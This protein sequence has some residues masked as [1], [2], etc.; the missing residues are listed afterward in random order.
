MA[1]GLASIDEGCTLCG[2]CVSACSANAIE[3]T[4]E[5]TKGLDVTNHSGIWVFAEQVDG[6]IRRV[7]FE[8]LGEARRLAA[9]GQTVSA[10]LFGCDLNS[11]SQQLISY[12]ADRVFSADS[13]ALAAYNDELYAD[14]LAQ[15]AASRRPEIVLIGATG[16][17]RSLAPRVAS[18]LDTGL[19]ADCT[20]LAIEPDSS[21]LLQT[22]PAF[23][24][25]LMATIICPHH[26]PQ[27]ATVRPGVMK[28]LTPDYQRCG[29][30]IN[31]ALNEPTQLR[32]RVLS[33]WRSRDSEATLTE[34]DVVV[35]VG[36]GIGSRNNVQLAKQL[37][38][39]LGG[40]LGATRAAV[41]AGWVSYHQQIGQTG[42]T[43]SPRLYIACGISGAVQHLAGISSAD[44][45]VAINQDPEAPIF[46][47]A[48]YCLVGDVLEVLPALL[49]RLPK[50]GSP[51]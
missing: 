14:L 33:V 48:H 50:T 26:R 16:N 36:K 41:E 43:V 19:T 4:Q 47:V 24:G 7:A 49:A 13:P 6:Q 5:L 51:T 37:A 11:A 38:E 45:I 23:G 21:L 9:S 12:G 8:L 28:A 46:Q 10:V 30:V 25:N 22:R 27:M 2:S 35:A 39:R 1:D 40:V 29:E 44:T 17:G 18:R 32:T 34:A 15:L 42:K 31:V 20:E 3:L